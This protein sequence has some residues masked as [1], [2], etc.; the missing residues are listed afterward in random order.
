MRTND[1]RPMTAEQLEALIAQALDGVTLSDTGASDALEALLD[2][3]AADPFNSPTLV[4]EVRA[5]YLADH[6]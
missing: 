1:A 5:Q 2:E 6:G 4:G 3:L